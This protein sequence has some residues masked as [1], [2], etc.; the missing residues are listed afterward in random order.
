MKAPARPDRRGAALLLVLA[1]LVLS[2]VSC[3]IAARSASTLFAQRRSDRASRVA[4]ELLHALGAP[5][6][7]WIGTMAPTA[8]L[9]TDVEEPRLDVLRDSIRLGEFDA[10][11]TVVA[12]DQLGMVPLKLIDTTSPLTSTLPQ[13]LSGVLKTAADLVSE[14]IQL[15]L[16]EFVR[17]KMDNGWRVYPSTSHKDSEQAIGA[18][19]A[20]HSSDAGAININTAPQ[21]LLTAAMREAGRGGVESVLDARTRGIATTLAS[22]PTQSLQRT[23]KIVTRSDLWSF[24]IDIRV[25]PV[26]RSWWCVYQANQCVQRLVIPE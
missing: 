15:G 12:F 17:D 5:I 1:A 16:D 8:V 20:T 7:H 14:D 9:P 24:R 4:D 26:T 21:H 2:T 6:Q 23:A 13:S 18:L 10:E 22:Q 3:A 25:G 19:V 11:I